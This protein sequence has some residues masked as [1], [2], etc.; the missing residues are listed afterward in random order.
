[1]QRWSCKVCPNQLIKYELLCNNIFI[2]ES[3]T[4]RVLKLRNTD[5]RKQLLVSQVHDNSQE[6]LLVSLQEQML[7]IPGKLI[8]YTFI[9]FPNHKLFV[10]MQ[11]APGVMDGC[12]L[13]MWT[14][15]Q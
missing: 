3:F 13:G 10:D 6:M 5:A 12:L 9:S 8:I 2:W 15:F 1:M 11:P 14:R 7:Q 4:S